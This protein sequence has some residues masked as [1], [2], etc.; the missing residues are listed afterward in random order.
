M[1]IKC[2]NDR[3]KIGGKN[4]VANFLGRNAA[5]LGRN[6][7]KLFLLR[8]MYGFDVFFSGFIF[9]FRNP[10]LFLRKLLPVNL[11]CIYL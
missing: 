2:V 4:F 7:K 3:T 6:E 11:W 8:K 5:R 1:N 9:I 10:L